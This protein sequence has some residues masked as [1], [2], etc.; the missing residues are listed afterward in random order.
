VAANTDPSTELREIRKA[1]K[2]SLRNFA[3]MLGLE[4]TTYKNYE[5]NAV[6]TVPNEVM[7]K[8]RSLQPVREFATPLIAIEVP[9]P[10]IGLIAASSPI[11]WVDPLDVEDTVYVP[12][13]MA[14]RRKDPS[15]Q[16]FV[17]RFC[18][19][20]V[21]DSMEPLLLENDL[22]VFECA[23]SPR[24]G[25]MVMHRSPDN[26][27]TVKQLKHDGTSYILRSLNRTYPDVPVN[28]HIVGFLVG[29][30]RQSG[31]RETTEYDATGILP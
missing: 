6:K 15:T 16:K 19:R 29:I 4:F 3:E 20:V 17:A 22:L 27:I 7:V 13:R 24:M 28:G 2:L 11:D 31:S 14:D 21:G 18:C 23:E 1:L 9:L 8:A 5:Y 30:V 26:L 10:Y 25:L 12:T